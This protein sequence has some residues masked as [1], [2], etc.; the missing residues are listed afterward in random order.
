MTPVRTRR[1]W[2]LSH[3]VGAWL[4]YWV[5]LITAVVWRAIPI[6]WRVSRADGHGSASGG[7]ENGTLQAKVMDGT[8]AV[9]T[10]SVSLTTAALWLVVPPLVLWVLWLAAQGRDD[11]VETVPDARRDALGEGSPQMPAQRERVAEPWRRDTPA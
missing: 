5:L 9:W 10:G 6:I 2:R 7:F 1:R 11:A 3:L 8:N 4:A